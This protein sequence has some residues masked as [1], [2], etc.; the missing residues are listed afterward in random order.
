MTTLIALA[1]GEQGGSALGLGAMSARSADDDLV[2]AT[3]VPTP[4]PPDPIRFDAGYQALQ[5]KDAQHSLDQA[6]DTIGPG[7]RVRYLLHQARSVSSGLLE[8]TEQTSADTV[9]LGSARAGGLGRVSL[10]GV[11]ERVLHSCGVAVLVAPSGFRQPEES[12]IARLTVAFGRSDGVSDLVR[13]SAELAQQ[14]AADLRVACFAIHPPMA[15]GSAAERTES[16]IV[17]D[18]AQQLAPGIQDALNASSSVAV[19]TAVETV[20]GQG[21]S[22]SEALGGVSWA[23]GDVLV[24]GSSRS[25]VSQFFLGSHATKIVR[26]SP[27]PVLVVPRVRRG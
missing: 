9:V 15:V 25:A 22:W 17:Q 7:L 10:G 21:R 20:V 14:I 5:R 11:A 13:T 2:V 23:D 26:S 4:W 1:P 27:V 3:I 18:W 24:I 12:R 19:D 6:A 16:L 8:L